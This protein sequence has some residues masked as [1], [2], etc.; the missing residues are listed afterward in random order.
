MRSRKPIAD[1]VDVDCLRCFQDWKR[2][3]TICS[4]SEFPDEDYAI[5]IASSLA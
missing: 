3:E 4:V 1:F 2:W 5:T